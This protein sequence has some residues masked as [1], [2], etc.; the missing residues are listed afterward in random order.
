MG[1]LHIDLGHLFLRVVLQLRQNPI[2]LHWQS[3]WTDTQL[4]TWSE[5]ARLPWTRSGDRLAL[6]HA[7]AGWMAMAVRRDDSPFLPGLEGQVI[8]RSRRVVPRAP[9]ATASGQR[10]TVIAE[11]AVSQGLDALSYGVPEALLATAVAGARAT[12]PLRGQLAV[13][14]ILQTRP[15]VADEPLLAKLRPL[16]A[17][18]ADS[19]PLPAEL[20][21]TVR[22]LARYYHAPLGAAARACLPAALRRTGVGSDQAADKQQPWVGATWLR[23]WPDD[24][25]RA[26]TRVLHRI[27]AEGSLPLAELRRKARPDPS[28]AAQISAPQGDG[29]RAAEPAL[30]GAAKTVAAPTEMLEALEQRGL[31]RLWQQRVLRDPLGMRE[32]VPGDEA[33]ALTADQTVAVQALQSAISAQTF[34]GFL[35]HGVTGSGKTEVY[36]QAIDR[37]LSLGQGAIV[38]VPEIAL[39]PQLVRRFRARFGDQVAALH[40]AMSEGERLDQLDLVQGG[41][42]RIVIG[43]RSALF[44]PMARLGVLVVDECHDSSFKQ[45]AG[46]RYHA[47]DVAL[48]R[49]RAAGAVCVLGSATP[50]CEE[51]ALAAAGR[52]TTLRLPGRAVAL[53]LPTVQVI[54]LRTA[55]RL[56]DI[57]TDRP[58]MLSHELLDAIAQ[59]VA[60]GE[61]VILLH[62]RRGYA[63][64]MVCAACGTAV[65]CPECAVSLT[66]HKSSGRL[67]C[68]WCDLSLPLGISCPTCGARNLLG[69][70]AGTERIEVTLGAALPQVRMARFDRDTASGQQLHDILGRFRNRELDLLVGTQMLAKGHDFPAV[71]L[72]GVILAEAGLGVADFRAA[73]RTFQLLTQVA[74]RAGRGHRP[75]RVLVQTH[76]P[77]HVAIRYALHQDHA[78]FTAQELESRRRSCYPP[79]AYLALLET[80]HAD[81]QLARAAMQQAVTAL[82]SFGAQ[83]RGPVMAQMSKVRNVWRI[84]AL[85][86]SEQRSSLHQWLTRLRSEVVPQLPAVVELT[87]DVDPASFG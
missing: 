52:L 47:R 4:Q 55:E 12:V 62:N 81:E 13:G 46:L 70:G 64:S 8:Q 71:T 26:E 66:L 72:V 40:S 1:L 29:P 85:L 80:R 59:T 15:V 63:T 68:H 21:E 10:F 77:D 73:E 60:R 87:I 31:I 18:P 69:V 9:D 25:T 51:M 14:L 11:V 27:E 78:G 67:R 54:D 49:A 42:R 17:I 7:L 16:L 48:V 61:Q 37:A 43:P 53:T 45:Q 41:Q 23:P 3:Q 76:Q 20:L 44:A 19:P 33:L 32:P 28:P 34:S 84:H 50:G 38:L 36:L 74:G 57:E 75:G 86:R 6:G 83:V 5:I 22:F 79:Y 82:E 24:L 56:R 30:P 35:L 65:E 39:T 2:L 58:S